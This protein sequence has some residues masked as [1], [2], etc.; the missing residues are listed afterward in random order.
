MRVLLVNKFLHHVG[1]VETYLQWLAHALHHAGH[2]VA[3]VGMAPPEGR[4]VMPF[5]EV[6]IWETATRGFA[7][8]TPGRARSAAF[9]VWS[10]QAGLVMRRALTEFE[11][12]VVHFHGTCFQLTPAVV[13]EVA[14]R[15]GACVITAHE[16][17]L[18]CANQL[19]FDDGA[20]SICTAC[21][22]ASRVTKVVAPLRRRCLKGSLPVSILGAI[23]GQVA[24]RTWRTARPGVITPSQ[25]MRRVLLADGW[26][27]EQ[28]RHLPL[29]WGQKAAL[30]AT[31]EP[32]THMRDSVTFLGR[33]AQVK[34]A[35][36]L[37]RVWRDLAPRH[38]SVTLRLAGEG[39][40]RAHL[41]RLAA[42]GDIPRVEFLGRLAAPQVRELLDRSILT[43]HPSRCHDN[44]PYSVRESLIAGV[45]AIVSDL[46]GM[47]ELVG[48]TSGQVVRHDDV[49]AWRRALE[50]EIDASRA[51]S[52]ALNA[53]VRRR[54]ASDEEHLE[55]LLDIYRARRRSV[56]LSC[57]NESS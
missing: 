33:L 3:L 36:L 48:P 4:S 28:V 40:E 9:S 12:D 16:Y 46:G 1:G 38:P 50:D 35:D 45:P 2:D 43:A 8:G 44:S 56:A 19:L 6:P 57:R 14:R 10:P 34:G 30:D 54:A 23:E 32:S 42:E 51:G 25:F 7:A 47:P 13:A 53:E 18:T 55:E 20:G 31:V 29:P 52:A 22:G 17:K 15:D 39:E 5:P 26:P 49:A 21:V 24:D 27:E 41:E 11:P 37:L